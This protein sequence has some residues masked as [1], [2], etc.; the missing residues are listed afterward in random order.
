M[1]V[2]TGLAAH[3]G[4]QFGDEYAGNLFVG[5]YDPAHVRRIVLDGVDLVDETVLVQ[6]TE[7]GIQQKP[8]DVVLAPDGSLWI[9]TFRTIWRVRRE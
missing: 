8:L 4:T 6:F 5:C 9:S 2:P 1:I 7:Q 3:D